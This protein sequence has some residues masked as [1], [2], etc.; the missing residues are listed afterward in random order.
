MVFHEITK[1]AIVR[2]L[3]ETRDVDVRLVDSQETRRILDRLYGY[4]VSPVLWKKVMRGLSAGRV[5]SVAT[6][7]V[8]D[9][10]LERIRF[11]VASYWDVVGTFEPGPF[12][13]RLV[14]VDGKRVAQ[15]RD[16]GSTGTTDDSVLVLD[17]EQ[18]TALARDLDGRP[19][20]VT[21][22]EEKPYRRSPAAPVPH[23]DAPAG[24]EPEVALL[25]ADDDAGRPAALRER[26]HHVHAHGL[27]CAVRRPPY[28]PHGHMRSGRTAQRPFP[29]PPAGTSGRS[30][31][32]RRRTR[33]SGR[34]GTSSALP[35]RSPARFRATSWL[36]T[37]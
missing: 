23:L 28:V 25:L 15:G 7:L 31:T 33:R 36:S 9:R 26:L 13:A 17:E 19:F 12:E 22:V 4:E 32:R 8:V 37:S 29:T 14:A 20:A 18:A 1:D 30:R 21:S 6:R 2:A 10:E 5:Q 34:P 11:V 3:D 35:K 16:F 27:G 24:G